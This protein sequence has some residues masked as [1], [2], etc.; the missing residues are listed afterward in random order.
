MRGG[1]STSMRHSLLCTAIASVLLAAPVA[2]GAQTG[3]QTG[4]TASPA[5]S[6]WPVRTSA[7]VD[8]WLHS[9]A[10]I[11]TDSALVPLYRRG[12][13][14]SV[15]AVRRSANVLTALD[16]NREALARRLAVSPA[17]LNA[18]F[19][20]FEFASWAEM[21][22]AAEKFLQFA[23]EPRRAPDQRVA[24][25]VALFASIFG[26]DADREWLRLFLASAE[27]ERIKWFGA[28]QE[29]ILL[30]RAT[31]VQRVD[32]LWRTSYR[33]KFERLLNNTSQR[34]G[35]LLL[36]IP[37]GGE[38]RT[39]N[40]QDRRTVVAVPLPAR[41]D[42]AIESILVL[43]HEA[44]GTLVGGVVADN[45][46][47][48]EKREGTTDRYVSAGQTRAGAMVIERVAPELL[49]PYMRYYLAQS[50]ASL[51]GGVKAAFLRVFDVPKSISD[52]LMKQIEIVLGGI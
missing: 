5:S 35:E 42:D 2:A 16:G 12:Y 11:S 9:F 32:S 20:P 36:S 52:G 6:R 24:A 47:P 48:A 26:G 44:T 21:K 33:Q 22:S 31:V 28:E 45:T 25:Q 14:D 4:T 1:V 51:D 30:A 46:S 50:G 29:R 37:I 34:N 18:Q 13:R 38:G 39:G 23:G 10:M 19:L 43:A 27:D 40:G 49:E 41:A 15:L 17:Y 3:A 8:L 7:H